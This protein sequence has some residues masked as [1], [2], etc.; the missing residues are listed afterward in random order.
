MSGRGIHGRFGS[1]A[2]AG[3]PGLH[4]RGFHWLPWSRRLRGRYPLGGQDQRDKRRRAELHQPEDGT[5]RRVRCLGDHRGGI[6]GERLLRCFLPHQLHEEGLVQ[7]VARESMAQPPQRAD[8]EQRSMGEA[9]GSDAAPP[10]SAMEEGP[11]APKDPRPTQEWQRAGR[12]ARRGR[13]KGSNETLNL[14]LT[15]TK[16]LL[17]TIPK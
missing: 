11:G 15:M 16:W 3:G 2:W 14:A 5:Y 7:E 10:E 8:S 17:Q 1:V 4:G 13:Q 9:P 6:Y 12:R